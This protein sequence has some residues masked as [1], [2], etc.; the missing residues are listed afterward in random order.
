V[1]IG[2]FIIQGSQPTTVVLRAIGHSLAARGLSDALIDPVIEVRNAAGT[3]VAQNDDWT[4]GPDAETIA[5]Y[6]LDPANGYES[7]VFQTLNPGAY[8]AI[9]KAFDNGNG[10][11]TGSGLV[12]LYDVHASSGRAGNISTRGQ[13]LTGDGVMIGGFVIG[14]SVP[15]EVVIRGIGPSLATSGVANALA[16]PT[17]ELHDATGAVIASNDNWP[18]DPGAGGVQNAGLA[19]T[20]PVE[21]ALDRTLSPG[22]YTVILRGVNDTTG[23]GLI[24]VYD[25]SPS[26]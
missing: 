17:I 7:A 1:L 22:A 4:S 14:G 25:R 8:T 11:L 15:K 6:Q 20:E 12:E 9:V 18:S 26:P 24:E 5:S 19:P 23:V 13:V 21:S 16:N 2:G 3:I 10:D